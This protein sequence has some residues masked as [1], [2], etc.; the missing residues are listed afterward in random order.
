MAAKLYQTSH[1]RLPSQCII[2][3]ATYESTI[4]E[5]KKVDQTSHQALPQL[6]ILPVAYELDI[7]TEYADQMNHQTYTDQVNTLL[8]A[9]E[10]ETEQ[11][12]STQMSHQMKEVPCILAPST[13]IFF[14]IAPFAPPNNHT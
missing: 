13:Q 10:L 9:Y 8:V 3:L 14:I 1:Q 5:E 11:S 12:Q 4:E 7:E 2:L 6:M